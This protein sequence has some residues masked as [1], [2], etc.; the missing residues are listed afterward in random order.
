[1]LLLGSAGQ[2]CSE[3]DPPKGYRLVLVAQQHCLHAEFKVK[4][5]HVKGNKVCKRHGTVHLARAYQP[6]SVTSSTI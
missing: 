3:P 1:M 4:R 5:F 2:H 6:E